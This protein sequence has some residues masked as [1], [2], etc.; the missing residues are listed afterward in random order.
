MGQT[1][2]ALE[3]MIRALL[4]RADVMV[5]STHLLYFLLSPLRLFRIA[6]VPSL[7]GAFWPASLRPRSF[8]SRIIHRLNGRF[9]NRIASATICVSPECERQIREI[10]PHVRG[11]IHQVR[12]HYRRA[13]FDRIQPPCS[14]DRQP[15]CIMF[16]GRLVRHKGVFEILNVADWLQQRHPGQYRW[17]IC[18]SGPAFA[19][20]E[21]AVHHKALSNL[22]HLNGQLS[23]HQMVEAYGRSHVIVV[24]TTRGFAEGLNK[25]AVEAILSGRPLVTSRLSNALDVLNGAVI[26]VPPDDLKAYELA[27]VRLKEDVAFY[28]SKCAA[29]REA[30]AQFYDRD[31]AWGTALRRILDSLFP[32]RCAAPAQMCARE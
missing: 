3:L 9:W 6:V 11:K 2:Y 31:Q 5:I 13:C 8:K 28:E 27:L 19:E 26:E 14:L 22:F 1:W 25:V 18:G 20:L 12:A 30:Q 23:Q 16:A 4:F 24:P 7:H 32:G 10:A 15:F 21:S 29:C 17:E